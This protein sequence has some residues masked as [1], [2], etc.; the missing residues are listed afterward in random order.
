MISTD[1]VI[2]L[3]AA[4]CPG[5]ENSATLR[6]RADFVRGFRAAEQRLMALTALTDAQEVAYNPAFE[7]IWKAYPSRSGDSKKDA[8]KAWQARIKAGASQLEISEGVRRYAKYVQVGQVAPEFIEP[9]E[10]FFG[11]ADYYKLPW[12]PSIK[13]ALRH[14]GFGQVDD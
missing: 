10:T 6:R 12:V 2:A 9:G 14:T 7:V 3:F 5:E 1:E 11:P 4:E 8:Y 13:K